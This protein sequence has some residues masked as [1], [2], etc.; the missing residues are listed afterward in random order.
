MNAI[1]ILLL[2]LVLL[3]I[4][5]ICYGSWL[6]RQ[7]G[8]D[9]T[10][11]TPAHTMRDGIDY[12]PTKAPVLM[13]HHFAS[14]AGA[15]PINGPIMAAVFGWVP[16]FL[17]LIIGGI[18]IGAVHDFSSLFASVRNKGQSIGVIIQQTLG[19]S[20][21]RLFIIFSWLTLVLV[22]AAF[23]DIVAS[24]FVGFT[25]DGA[26]LTPNAS[27]AS[28]S[29]IFV[30]VAIIFGLI[31]SRISQ[32]TVKSC[33][34]GIAL[35]VLCVWLGMKFPIYLTKPVWMYIVLG[36]IFVAS[37]TP[38]WILLQPRDFLNSFLLYAMMI[39]AVVG[40][41]ASNPTISLPAF[42]SWEPIPGW[43]LFPILFITIACGSISGFHS[44]ISSGTTAKQLD[45][46]AD[47]KPIGY[48]AM[49]IETS[50][51]VTAL[52][53]VGVYVNGS[54]LTGTPPMIFANGV[55]N[56]VA[57]V[58]MPRDVAYTVL[59]LAIASFALTSLDT[60]TR[61]G[62]YMFQEFFTL[63][64]AKGEPSAL[65]KLLVNNYVST[66]ITV[67]FGF[68]LA[69]NGYQNIWPLFGSAN[70][71]L[72]ALA[73]LG[74]SLWLGKVGRNNKMLFIPTAF[75]LFA[76]LTALAMSVYGN[77]QRF[78]A[79]TAKFESHGLQIIFGVL[80]FVLAVVLAVNGA[81]KLMEPKGSSN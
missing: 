74:V 44:L 66:A 51:A 41:I 34:L 52:I 56:F 46:E 43:T 58:G 5:Y 31:L 14:I 26:Q 65:R 21:K 54:K 19:I 62:R 30:F 70:Q 59:I 48:G 1:V 17:W 18:F 47:A 53:A 3:A 80:L 77:V 67:G 68:L 10:K 72:A 6:A 32:S 81:K 73:L 79:G 37:V 75:M 64:E 40:I 60:A 7:W 25:K 22:V 16:V 35:V 27:A 15:G 13:G 57:T 8:I 78:A 4:A 55:A 38:V 69:T 39:M 23:A 11:P 9:P 24:T 12:I 71:L 76:T 20:G 28:T 42:T 33:A 63:D 49:L 45:S 36:Y 61:L 50:L 2:A 29:I